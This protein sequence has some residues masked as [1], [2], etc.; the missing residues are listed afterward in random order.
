MFSSALVV[1][2][3]IS[4]FAL[5]VGATT[6]S[7][8]AIS[9]LALQRV[10]TPSVN[11]TW[12]DISLIYQDEW[13]D[14]AEVDEEIELIH[15]TVPELVDIEV[16]GES[17]LGRNITC[18]RITNELNTEQKAKT[19]VV[20]H[21][22]AREQITVE[23]SLRFIIY[24]L[25][26]Y[27]EDE[28]ITEYVDTQEIYVIPTLNPDGL[29]RVVNE[30]DYW[31]RKN[32]RPYD[33]DG[34]GLFDEDPW[35]DADGDGYVSGF[36]VY[37]KT[38]PG[39]E[40]EFQYT[41][42]EG[43]DDDGDGFF[44]EDYIGLVDLNRNYATGWGSGSSSSDVRS[45]VYHGP[46]AFSEPETQAY[47]D[48]TS[49]H[50]FAMVYS[51][52]SGINCTYF[53]TNYYDN[54]YESTLYYYVVQDFATMYP[55]GFNEFY[56]FTAQTSNGQYDK[57]Q[58][59]SAPSGMWGAWMYVEQ[60]TTLPITFEVYHNGSADAPSTY[61]DIVD[62]STHLIQ[63]WHEIFG[64]FT[65]D[66]AYI[67]DLWQYYIP[68]FDYLLEMTPRLAATLGV[69]S[70]AT[71]Q[72]EEMSLSVS[73]N[74]LSP[75]L[76]T[77]EA[78]ELRGGDGTLLHL[79]SALDGGNSHILPITITLPVDLNETGYILRLGNE[80]SGYTQFLLT[81]A[82]SST[83]PDL[84]LPAIVIVTLVA[85]VIVVYYVKVYRKTH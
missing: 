26:N 15:S 52:H 57:P 46:T 25:N 62:N 73:I 16:I 4:T 49:Q 59:A 3:L 84:L 56:G 44:N 34:D 43:I 51:L 21:H 58:L 30:E 5:S 79:W 75:R 24:L 48:W 39:G 40:P 18:V 70:Y 66:D 53:P 65:P 77:E 27:G 76:S 31:L 36:D 23:L 1:L 67:E 41:Y 22:H 61:V 33:D 29:E 47:R 37:T 78:I 11:R 19:Q 45:Q 55:V 72:D 42:Y 60:G 81:S 10:E 9:T 64:Y 6:T 14:P 68:A 28:T 74:C 69:A 35:D 63:E 38:G 82:A 13:H 8:N 20:A 50:T 32:L 83:S 80:Y 85:V 54:W 7:D 71:Q 12:S 17:Y 2:L